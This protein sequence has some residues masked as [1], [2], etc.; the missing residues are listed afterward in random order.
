MSAPSAPPDGATEASSSGS[1]GAVV[2]AGGGGTGSAD[3]IARV[4]RQLASLV[5]APRGKQVKQRYAFWETQ[6]VVQFSDS[7]AEVCVVC[8]WGG[9]GAVC[10]RAHAPR[11]RP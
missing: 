1:G 3:M 8:V 9:G 11:A 5:S 2:P 6:P 7:N 4:Q 10:A